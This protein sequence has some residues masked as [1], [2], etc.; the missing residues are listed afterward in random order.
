MIYDF[1]PDAEEEFIEA[2]AYYEPRR[3]AP[4]AVHLIPTG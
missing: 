4:S 1:H 2:A 3:L